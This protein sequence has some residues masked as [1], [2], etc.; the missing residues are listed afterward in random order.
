MKT[1]NLRKIRRL[2]KLW[3]KFPLYSFGK[4]DAL[5]IEGCNKL[6]NVIPS[7]VVG[8]LQSLRNLK[9]TN[10]KSMKEIFDL[11][12]CERRDTEDMHNLQN[13]HVE[14][15]PNLKHVWNKDP[16]GIL[17]FK[18]LKNI[19]VKEC[20]NLI[21]IFPV[22]IAMGLEKLE[23]L[24]VLNCHKL[25]EIVSKG[26]TKKVSSILFEFPKLTKEVLIS[27]LAP[28]HSFLHCHSITITPYIKHHVWI[29]LCF[30]LLKHFL[31]KLIQ[32]YI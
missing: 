29:S 20:V 10:C 11:R 25:K 32:T 7:Y 27:L 8:R 17:N 12:G 30:L 3:G 13:V 9:V 6:E 21:Y 18:K 15:L 16:K 28:M 24:E 19:W 14:A 1:I 4:L 31:E 22:S 2:K 26:G 23:Y 5:I